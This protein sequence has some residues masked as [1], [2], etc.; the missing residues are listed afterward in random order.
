M[1]INLDGLFEFFR[2]KS[3][4]L[5]DQIT[6]NSLFTMIKDAK[7]E[8]E[9]KNKVVELAKFLISDVDIQIYKIGMSKEVVID[10]LGELLYQHRKDILEMC[11]NQYKGDK[12]NILA[13]PYIETMKKAVV[14]RSLLNPNNYKIILKIGDQNFK[15]D[16]KKNE[17][18]YEFENKR[19][20]NKSGIKFKKI[21]LVK[22][23]RKMFKKAVF[24]KFTY[25][26]LMRQ[27]IEKSLK[28]ANLEKEK[29]KEN[30]FTK[31]L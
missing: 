14:S 22:L 21:K 30:N 29:S 25:K 27:G 23:A 5:V 9:D 8:D 19:V 15:I 7:D 6:K 12:N 10:M 13:P 1:E 3:F 28:E 24:K 18:G 4:K 20:T 2:K 17:H 26:D 11:E 16:C 31:Q